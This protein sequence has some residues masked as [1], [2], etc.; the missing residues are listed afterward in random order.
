MGCLLDQRFSGLQKVG[1]GGPLVLGDRDLLLCQ[2][3][4]GWQVKKN[5]CYCVIREA[6]WTDFWP[7]LWEESTLAGRG[8][9]V[10]LSAL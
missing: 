8:C 4:A 9:R 2:L 3:L 1:L 7:E 6:K 5:P 10:S